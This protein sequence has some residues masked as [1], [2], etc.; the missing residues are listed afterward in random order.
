[1]VIII[2]YINIFVASSELCIFNI[3]FIY[4][5][6]IFYKTKSFRSHVTMFYPEN[7]PG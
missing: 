2:I 3:S 4:K 5:Q 1:M 6:A 7:I